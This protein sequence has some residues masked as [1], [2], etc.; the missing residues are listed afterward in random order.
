MSEYTVFLATL[1]LCCLPL[2]LAL[3][4][5]G[6]PALAA[7]LCL[8][9][10]KR[11]KVFRDKFGQQTTTFALFAGLVALFALAGGALTLVS[12]LPDV[13]LFWL[14]WPLPDAPLA[15][16]LGGAALLLLVYRA[17]WRSLAGARVLHSLL[18]ILASLCG[19]VFGY[20]CLAALRHF[21]LSPTTPAA[22][23]AYFLPEKTS[24]VWLMAPLTL[25]LSFASAAALGACYLIYRRDKDDFGRDYYNYVLKLCA[26]LALAATLLALGVQGGLCW[27]LWSLVHE[28]PIRPVFFWG[29]SLSGAFA[30]LACLLWILVLRSKN[31]LRMKLHLVA[32]AVLFWSAVTGQLGGYGL[33]YLG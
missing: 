6:L 11:L 33:F 20:L 24:A 27:K 15:G 9:P 30:L 25:L 3:A 12:R 22:E 2:T 29:Q 31:P 28:M 26:K 7:S 13:A 14:G 16:C 1:A 4:A 23:Q 10:P 21:L 17:S 5:S 32:G 18:G 19:W 8:R